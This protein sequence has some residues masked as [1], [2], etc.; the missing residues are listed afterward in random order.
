MK[1]IL[2]VFAVIITFALS[3]TAQVD[4]INKIKDNASEK[5]KEGFQFTPVV[6]NYTTDVKNQGRSGTCWSYCS[7]SFIE[8]EMKRMCTWIRAISTC[9]CTDT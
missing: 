3:V 6:R 2:S 4:L 5:A 8:S 1:K 9:A 7:S